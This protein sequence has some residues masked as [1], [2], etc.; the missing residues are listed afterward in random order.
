MELPS[1]E[2]A[3]AFRS[4]LLSWS[5]EN[6]RKY[7]WRETDSPYRVLVAEILLQKTFAD[8]VEPIYNK[9]IY[10]YPDLETLA[11]ADV[12]EVASLLK[13]LGLQ[14]VRAQALIDI[15]TEYAKVGIPDNEGELLQLPYVGPYAA[16]AT[17]CFA[18]D[19]RRPVVDANVVRIYNRVFGTDFTPQNDEAWELAERMLPENDYQRFNLALLDF[20][21]KICTADSPLCP[22]CNYRDRCAYYATK[23]QS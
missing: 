4:L 16:N 10:R 13:P 11:N 19:R 15:A 18:F 9:F 7:P 1:S 3:D 2:E 14:N 5:K 6:L 8:K 22:E 12:D 17:L 23:T 21:A 20:G